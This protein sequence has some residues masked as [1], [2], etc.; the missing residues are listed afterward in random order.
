MATL[1][2]VAEQDA[3]AQQSAEP[4][5]LRRLPR[6]LPAS[7]GTEVSVVAPCYNEEANV[8][9]LTERTLRMFDDHGLR[10]ELIL[11]DDAS[12][13]RTAA[14][15][16][17]LAA[18]HPRVIALHHERNR[19]IEGGWRSGFERS[20][21][22]YVCF[23]DADL[24]NLPED[25][26]RLYEE[27]RF[28]SADMV[29][30][31]RSTIGRL[32]DARYTLSKG[33]NF[34]LNTI[35][36]MRMH[37]SKSG[38]VLA[39]REAVEDV[40]DHRLRYRYFQ[41]F[42]TIAAHAKNYSIGQIETLFQ[43][44][45]AGKSFIGRFPLKL[46]L[47][48][49]WDIAKAF[50]E[51][52]VFRRRRSVLGEYVAAH[53]PEQQ[54]P[55]LR[56]PLRRMLYALFFLSMPLH[57]WLITRNARWLLE[58]LKQSQWLSPEALRELQER[59]LR[60]LVRHAY[61]T[62]PYYRRALDEAGLRPEDINHLEDLQRL[63]LLTKDAVRKHLYFDLFSKSHHKPD[64][65]R[66]ATSGSTGEP[67]VVYVER[68]QLEMRWAATIRSMEWTGWR[69]GDPQARLWHQ[70]LGMSLSQT[71]RERLDAFLMRRLFIPAYELRSDNLPG[72]LRKLARRRP[73]LIDGYAESFNFL[74]YFAQQQ[75]IADLRPRAIMSSAQTLPEQ[76]RQTI[77][78]QFQTEV[79]D[80]Y[81][82]REFSGIAY[83]CAR[84]SG[85]HVVAES[86]VVELLKDGR[87]AQPGE[88]GEVVITDLNNYCMPLI[89][90]RIGDLAV[91]M[92]NTAP[93][94]CG[95]GLPRIG[96]IEGRVQSIVL[97]K[98]G[99]WLP[100]TF[101]A[102][103]F[104]DHEFAVR[105]YQVVQEEAGRFELKV[106][107]GAQFSDERFQEILGDLRRVVGADMEV[108]VRFVDSIPLGRTGKR[109]GVVSKLGLEFQALR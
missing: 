1:G 63:P 72:F 50:V 23:I 37:D 52:R 18:E 48:V 64:M 2:S 17:A 28:T 74:A 21:G 77:E 36:G 92:D 56:G 66:V 32:R 42:I 96:R 61:R 95:R 43:D 25:I 91:A 46:L 108:D 30:G 70:T 51:Y 104:K 60:R 97:C 76:V 68:R 83:E 78:R 47:A 106:V 15:I 102:H 13:D 90:Y 67:F 65:L 87:P 84:H 86:Y 89:R 88:I 59:R 101:F 10:G 24:Q 12:T 71:L 40:L 44:R 26:W 49:L 103:F 62:T 4:G 79:F 34:L 38:F 14:V 75:G 80:K 93:C 73:V 57:K 45:N 6:A 100:G 7:S 19:G 33:L 8:E 94:A 31:Y 69:W 22:S 3:A 5:P 39:T 85:H 58:R 109:Q 29:Q 81:G 54:D 82:S 105:Q 53:P 55:P 11:V 16:D 27:I 20:R 41:T 98:N 9:A 35:F 99:T 107:K